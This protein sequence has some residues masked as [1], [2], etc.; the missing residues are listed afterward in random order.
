MD[1]TPYPPEYENMPFVWPSDGQIRELAEREE[2]QEVADAWTAWLAEVGLSTVHI[3]PHGQSSFVVD[4]S[5]SRDRGVKDHPVPGAMVWV[6]GS[7]IKAQRVLRFSE[8]KGGGAGGKRGK[9]TFSKA[10]RRRLMRL[11]ATL[12]RDMVPVFV[13]L[14]YPGEYTQDSHQWKRDLDRFAKRFVRA[15]PGAFFV[16]RLEFQR[17]GAPHYHLMVYGAD[18]TQLLQWVGSNWYEVVRSGDERHLRAGTRVEKLRNIGGAYRYAAKYLGKVDQV[19][20]EGVGRWWGVV[21]R[22]N[23]E[24]AQIKPV[25]IPLTQHAACELMRYM[26]R[27]ARLRSRAYRSLTIICDAEYWF[28]KLDLLFETA[29]Y[30]SS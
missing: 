12:P 30:P 19:A 2:S 23:M 5:V 8:S 9:A 26:R 13:T 15:F 4:Q 10:S 29:W 21:C 24:Q 14:T 20:Y 18:Y 25:I 3:S 11:L 1:Y 22:D 7:L 17:R 6:G 28:L 27:Y 16:W